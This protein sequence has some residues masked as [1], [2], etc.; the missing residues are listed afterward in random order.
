MLIEY[1]QQVTVDC[2]NWE[3]LIALLTKEDDDGTSW[4]TT[5]IS[6]TNEEDDREYYVNQLS[7]YI[8]YQAVFRSSTWSLEQ[9][10]LVKFIEGFGAFYSLS[11]K[12]EKERNTMLNSVAEGIYLIIHVGVYENDFDPKQDRPNEI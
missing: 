11:N 6:L 7:E 4:A 1:S 5:F 8:G 3:A 9:G 12:S 10:C 2:N